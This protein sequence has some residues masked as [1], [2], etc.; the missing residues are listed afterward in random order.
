M[1][2]F[3]REDVTKLDQYIAQADFLERTRIETAAELLVHESD[4]SAAKA[5][6]EEQRKT[7]R[8]QLKQLNRK[9]QSAGDPEA[10]CHTEKQISDMKRQISTL[11][12]KIRTCRKEIGL[13]RT[14]AERSGHVEQNLAEIGRQKEIERKEL[15]EKNELRIGRGSR[16]GREDEPRRRGSRSKTDR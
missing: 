11:S 15:K 13:C 3:L 5:E 1:P 8:N 4:Q 10:S 9:M 7:L 6:L 12:D 16:T 14:I 2:V